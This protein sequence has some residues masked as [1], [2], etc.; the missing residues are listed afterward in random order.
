V[1]VIPL[2]GPLGLHCFRSAE[3]VILFSTLA[4]LPA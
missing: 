4:A 3:V 1:L 2:Y